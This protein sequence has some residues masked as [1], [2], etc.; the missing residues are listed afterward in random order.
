MDVTRPT[1]SVAIQG[2]GD[3]LDNGAAGPRNIR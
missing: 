3:V 2:P 1:W